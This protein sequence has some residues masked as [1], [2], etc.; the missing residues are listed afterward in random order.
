MSPAHRIHCWSSALKPTWSAEVLCLSRGGYTISGGPHVSRSINPD[1]TKLVS[2]VACCCV[3]CKRRLLASQ[4]MIPHKSCASPP[5]L[6]VLPTLSSVM[7]WSCFS[8]WFPPGLHI[9]GFFDTILL[10]EQLIYTMFLA[11]PN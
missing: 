6:W 4:P 2:D 7:V 5:I 9:R 1:P 11:C 3:K 10:P 8:H